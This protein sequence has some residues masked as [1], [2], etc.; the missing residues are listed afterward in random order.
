MDE[1]CGTYGGRKKCRESFG[2]ESFSR[3]T[4][5]SG[6]SDLFLRTLTLFSISRLRK[7]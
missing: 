7:D 2:G 5:F 4:L 3:M 1:A 6:I